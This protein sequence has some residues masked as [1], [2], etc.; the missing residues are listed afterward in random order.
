ML[1]QGP[2]RLCVQPVE[3]YLLIRLTRHLTYVRARSNAGKGG[4]VVLSRRRGRF[5][6]G[7]V[8][9]S[10]PRCC[11]NIGRPD[12][13]ALDIWVLDQLRALF[14]NATDNSTLTAQLRQDKT[15]FFLHLLGLDT[16]GHSYRPHSKV[17]RLRI[18]KRYADV[19]IPQEYMT[20]I[21]VVDTIVRQTES[22]L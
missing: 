10:Q 17:R 6:K 18:L 16:T 7:F 20:N 9:F 21:Q 1:I 15:V 12:A 8:S 13:T 5:H 22:L 14:H 2:F 4:Y 3:P 19:R 11:T